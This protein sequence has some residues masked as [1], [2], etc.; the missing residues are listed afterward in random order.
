VPTPQIWN[1]TRAFVLAVG[2]VVSVTGHALSEIPHPETDRP[3]SEQEAAPD[4]SQDEAPKGES[5]PGHLRPGEHTE[6]LR[7][8][9]LKD[10]PAARFLTEL[11]G[12]ALQPGGFKL[13]S[14]GVKSFGREFVEGS[15][16]PDTW[17]EADHI[18]SLPRRR[19]ENWQSAPPEKRVF[20][21]GSAEDAASV[22]ALQT[23]LEDNGFATF[24]YDN[25]KPLCASQVVG[26]FCS[27]A[28]SVVV[29]QTPEANRSSYVKA[30]IAKA[31][32]VK[33]LAPELV[34]MDPRDFLRS[35]AVSA[36]DTIGKVMQQAST[37]PAPGEPAF[38]VSG[39]VFAEIPCD[40]AKPACHR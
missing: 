24:F 33:R 6:A 9:L 29:M 35:A 30:E 23:H 28:H 17:L 11:D 37:P 34:L 5:R 40:P 8:A 21:I 10:H 22:H 2:L 26:A 39:L 25:C 13:V 36:V 4:K 20:I 31:R 27:Q 3:G 19:L 1:A 32:E 14:F 16:A 7:L 38:H 15:E 18:H 12:R